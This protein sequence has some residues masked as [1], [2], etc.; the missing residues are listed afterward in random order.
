MLLLQ[1]LKPGLHA[2]GRPDLSGGIYSDLKPHMH[3]QL[4]APSVR[5]LDPLL[6]FAIAL[7][8]TVNTIII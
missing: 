4:K 6:L 5:F 8:I 7:I 1:H 3:G 2:R